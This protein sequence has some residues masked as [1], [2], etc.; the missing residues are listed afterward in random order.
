MLNWIINFLNTNYGALTILISIATGLFW[1]IYRIFKLFRYISEKHKEFNDN[2]F[3]KYH[4]LIKNLAQSDTPGEAIKLDRQIA[5]VYELRNFPKYYE[6][7]IRILSGW[8][9]SRDKNGQKDYNRLYDEMRLTINFMKKKFILK[10]LFKKS[11]HHEEFTVEQINRGRERVR[12]DLN[13]GFIAA[14]TVLFGDFAG[15]YFKEE[16]QFK[17]Y[18]FIKI[19]LPLIVFFVMKLLL[20]P[21]KDTTS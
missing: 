21:E 3:E 14:L 16:Y 5:T 8:I 9:N 1:F 4:T 12:Y 7:S 2:Q 17:F 15:D 11:V 18:Y 20:K 6:I 19:L 10:N 13:I